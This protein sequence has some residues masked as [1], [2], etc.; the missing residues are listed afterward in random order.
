MKLNTFTI[1]IRVYKSFGYAILKLTWPIFRFIEVFSFIF[2]HNSFSKG[3]QYSLKNSNTKYNRVLASPLFSYILWYIIKTSYLNTSAFTLRDFRNKL[4][5]G[6]EYLTTLTLL[7]VCQ[8]AYSN[9]FLLRL[10][11]NRY[12]NML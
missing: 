10:T 2:I 7:N 6:K 12:P 4:N 11:K 8:H 1:I 3:C 5:T 9:E